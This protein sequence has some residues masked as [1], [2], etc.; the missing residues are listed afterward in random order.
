MKFQNSIYKEEQ[1]LDGHL[2]F[3]QQKIPYMGIHELRK[4]KLFLIPFYSIGVM[5]S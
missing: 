3:Q 4:K 2:I 1:N 5:F